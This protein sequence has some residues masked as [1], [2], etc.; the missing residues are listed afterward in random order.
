VASIQP[1]VFALMLLTPAVIFSQPIVAT[2]DPSGEIRDRRW[3]STFS[4][5]C[6]P[7][8]RT[9]GNPP[10]CRPIELAM[11]GEP[12]TSWSVVSGKLPA[13]VALRSDGK[14]EGIPSETGE[15]N[16]VIE[17]L[18][19]TFLRSSRAFHFHVNPMRERCVPPLAVAAAYSAC[20]LCS[21]PMRF[22]FTVLEGGLPPGMRYENLP[23]IP[24]GTTVG[25]L[26]GSPAE[27]GV[28]H[29]VGQCRAEDASVVFTWSLT[30]PVEEKTKNAGV[31]PLSITECPTRDAPPGA[32]SNERRP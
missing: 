30:I 22:S 10:T 27:S 8:P 26:T 1:Q 5:D 15:F 17:A 18:G 3:G 23:G 12:G 19:R 28:F 16:I 29:N 2:T 21:G 6:I 20:C 11:R 31:T 14:F 13:G 4:Y 24:A 7:V 9:P 25:Y 32:V